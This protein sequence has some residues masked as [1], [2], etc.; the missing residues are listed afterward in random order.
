MNTA[1]F[2]Q[3]DLPVLLA[4]VLASVAC[5]VV[6]CFLVLRRMALMG[7]AI[8]HAVLPGIVLAFLMTQ[9]MHGPPMFI[10]CAIIGVV[11][12]LLTEVIHRVGR[13][14]SNASMGVVFTVLFA[15]GVILIERYAGRA[16]HLD[17]DVVLYGAMETAIWPTAPDTWAGLLEPGAW[18]GFPSQVITL[19][20]MAAF[21]IAFVTVLFKELRITAFDPG[22]AAAQGISP[23]VMHYALMT[24]VAMTTVAA[25]EAVGSILVVA[26]LIV[27]GLI[28]SLLADRLGPM[29]VVAAVSAAVIATGGYAVSAAASL[30]AAGTIGVMLG[31]GLVVVGLVAP[32]HG[33]ISRAWQR[34]TIGAAVAREDGLGLLYRLSESGGDAPVPTERFDA[35][36]KTI[37]LSR[38]ARAIALRQLVQ[39]GE[40]QRDGDG[41]RL[42]ERGRREA[43]RLV[44][45]HRL[46][47]NYLVEELDLRPDHVHRSAMQLEHVTDERMRRRLAEYAREPTTDPHGRS[48]PPH[49]A[50]PGTTGDDR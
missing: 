28:G 37:G 33:W 24:V 40:V 4:G 2:L 6:G 16:V 5:S 46:W 31:V 11:T 32:Q 44:R 20:L 29:L 8:S 9:T 18:T 30:N 35:L 23:T 43:A 49:D 12:A 41:L 17:A 13:V 47:E 21:N 26:M 42:T 27:P 19:A 1:V 3:L 39:A 22:L 38:P 10:G 45:V 36:M 25:F 48:I 14:E 15:I 7:D 50:S 34:M